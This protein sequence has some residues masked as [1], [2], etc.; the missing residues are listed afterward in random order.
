MKVKNPMLVVTDMERSVA[1]YKKVFGFP[2]VMDFGANL[3][4]FEV[5]DNKDKDLKLPQKSEP[6]L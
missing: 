4:S 3:V 2:V 5:K 6:S 1:F